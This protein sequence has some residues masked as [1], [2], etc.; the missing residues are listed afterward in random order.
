MQFKLLTELISRTFVLLGKGEEL[1]KT[2]L[3][4]MDEINLLLSNF[5]MEVSRMTTRTSVEYSK[6]KYSNNVRLKGGY[7]KTELIGE[8]GLFW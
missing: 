4:N 8:V 5:R 3:A 7:P 2:S 1:Y 6:E